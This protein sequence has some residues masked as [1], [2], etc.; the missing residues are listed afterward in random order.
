M[1]L[2][3]RAR[4]AYSVQDYGGATPIE[5]VQLV[6]LRRFNDDGGAITELGRLN[7]GVHQDLEGFEVRQ[8]NFSEVEPGAVKAYHLHKRQTDVWYVPPGDR[9]LIVLHDCRKGSPT[10]GATMRFMLGDGRSRLLRIP[11]GVAH[12]CTNL[13]R[14]AATIIYFVD[15]QFD[16]DPAQTDE[17]RIP[18]DY[19]GAEIWEV[20]NG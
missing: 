15:V 1:E 20:V 16:P 13:G 7:Q 5:G 2:N 3:D 8:V 9:M 14:E 10:E 4:D 17:G 12:G 6:E 11:P 18:W 19:L